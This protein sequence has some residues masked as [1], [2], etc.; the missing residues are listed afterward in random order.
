MTVASALRAVAEGELATALDLL[1]EAPAG[2]RVAPR[3]MAYLETSVHNGVYAAPS[4]FQEFIEFGGNPRLYRRTIEAVRSIHHAA[5]PTAVLDIGCGDG[6]V[7]AATVGPSVALVDL[8]EPSSVLLG[9]AV[10]RFPAGTGLQPHNRGIVEHLDATTTRWDVTQSTFAF[11]SLAPAAR[12]ATLGALADRTRHLV[13]VEFDVPDFADGSMRHARYA[14]DRYELG[15][16]EYH[17][18]PS[19]I[20]DFLMPV[21]VGQFDPSTPRLTFEQSASSWQRDLAHAGFVDVEIEVI[22]DYWWAPA[23]VI[24]ARA[25][26]GQWGDRR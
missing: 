8:V 6:R 25:S 14:A 7:T 15:L 19:V 18:H 26:T 12:R 23:V 9:E 5:R 22:D 1:A 17:D 16:A 4:A 21:L 13:L 3:L 10:A 11:H 2:S 24:S 20:S